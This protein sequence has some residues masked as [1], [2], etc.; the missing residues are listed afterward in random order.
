M[1]DIL[2]RREQH[3]ATVILGCRRV[4]YYRIVTWTLK[5]PLNRDHGVYGIGTWHLGYYIG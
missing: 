2:L 3:R 4:L 5:V 1:E